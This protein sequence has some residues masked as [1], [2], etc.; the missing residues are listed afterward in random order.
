MKIPKFKNE[1]AFSKWLRKKIEELHPDTLVVNVTGTGY[2]MNGVHDLLLC[3][4][5]TFLSVELKMPGKELTALQDGF[6][7]KV[8]RAKGMPL[9]PCWPD[10]QRIEGLFG[11]LDEI[12]RSYERRVLRDSLTPEE[13]AEVV[14]EARAAI[15]AEAVGDE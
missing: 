13:V 4:Y 7:E 12:R 8:L 2:G 6:L 15:A 3:H 5:G 9:A 10:E 1:A 14:A 11:I